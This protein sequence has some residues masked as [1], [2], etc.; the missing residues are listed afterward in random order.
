M[1]G[2]GSSR[3]VVRRMDG[4]DAEAPSAFELW[5]EV[6]SEEH[7]WCCGAWEPAEVAFVAEQASGTSM[8]IP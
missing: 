3:S 4:E 1:D 7:F 8:C 2:E 5:M 6:C